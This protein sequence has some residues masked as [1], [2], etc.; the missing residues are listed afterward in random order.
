MRKHIFNGVGRACSINGC[1]RKFH[2]RGWCS[3]HYARWYRHGDPTVIERSPVGT[4]GYN[5][6]VKFTRE[7][8]GVWWD[9]HFSPHQHISSLKRGIEQFRQ[10]LASRELTRER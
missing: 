8:W 2:C 9:R 6:F 10:T 7:H 1:H 5:H 4:C 3:M